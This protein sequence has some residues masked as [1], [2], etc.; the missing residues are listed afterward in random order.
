MVKVSVIIPVYNAESFLSQCLDSICC[1]SL[2][3]IQIICVDDG[4]TDMSPQILEKYA[5]NDKRI[6]ILTQ[7]NQYAGAARNH[8]MKYAKGK[9]L[10]FLDADDIFGTEMLERMYERAEQ[11]EAEIV[12]CR[13][14]EF[15]QDG[16]EV[17]PPDWAFVDSFMKQKTLFS[18]ME[19]KLS[20]IFQ[21]ARGWAW[22][23]LFRRDYVKRCGYQYP[24]FRSS[25]DGFFV[26]ML[27]ARAQKLSY[28]DDFFIRHR[29]GIGNSLS[30]TKDEDWINGFRMLELIRDEL[31][32][33]KLYLP[34]EQSFLNMVADFLIWDLEST[35]SFEAYKNIFLCIKENTNGFLKHGREHYFRE[36]LWEWLSLTAKSTL[37]EYLFCG[38]ER[39]YESINWQAG[40]I[41]RM[42]AERDWVFPYYMIEKGRIL[43]LYGAG[44][45]GRAYYSQLMES[46]YCKEVI[47]VDKQYEQRR[48][49]GLDVDQREIIFQR[50]YDD[51]L[52]AIKEE[53][54]QEAVKN[55]L[56]ENGVS[57]HK[58]KSY[59]LA[60]NKRK[61]KMNEVTS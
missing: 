20:G 48:K 19:L 23:K 10:S 7:K 18:P 26:Y 14:E 13:Y 32:K 16:R 52:I 35:H 53:K 49:E 31:K 25:E 57:E 3:E 36:E 47:W 1:Q 45:I 41:E 58:I 6:Q 40:V 28:M 15:R 60:K 56:I 11:S 50:E 9:Y 4:S 59:C 55:W 37:E 12:L 39:D 44:E 51:I 61:E 17:Q 21:I 8:G 54:I 43:I 33:Q 22:D 24:P 30:E 34:Y 42:L 5:A 2:K 27:M 46:G 29:T 38:R